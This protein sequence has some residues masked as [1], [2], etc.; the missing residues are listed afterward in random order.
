MICNMNYIKFF[1]IAVVLC[2]FYF[3]SSCKDDSANTDS[4]TANSSNDKLADAVSNA[5]SDQ[6]YF[7]GSESCKECHH[8]FHELWATSRHGNSF[9][10]VTDEFVK[11][12]LPA[13][14]GT[15]E[16]ADAQYHADVDNKVITEQTPEGTKSYPM[17]YAVGGKNVFYLITELDGGKMQT[18][19]L[20]YDVMLKKWY[21]MAKSGVRHSHEFDDAPYHWKDYP[22][23]FNSRC[24]GCHVSQYSQNY[25][26]ETD[27][28]QTTWKE[29]GINCEACHGPASEHIRV[30]KEAMKE[31]KMPEDLKMI[32]AVQSHGSTPEAV[33]SAC[34]CCHTKGGAI[35]PSYIPGEDYYDH[36]DLATY[37]NVDYYPDGRDL[38][39]NYTFTSWSLSPCAKNSKLDCM[40]CHTSSGRYRFHDADK[41]NDACVECHKSKVDNIVKHSHHKEGA[42]KC[43]QC[44]MPTTRFGNM[45]RSDH[46][47]RPPMPSATIKFKS[48]NACNICHKRK[49]PEWADKKVRQWHEK[50][51]QKETI[52]VAELV[53]QARRGQWNNLPKMLEYVQAPDSSEIFANSL[54]RLMETCNDESK[55]PVL[56]KVMK[57]SESPLVRSSAAYAF[58]SNL[59][60]ESVA[61]LYEAASDKSRIVRVKAGV[62]L[63]QV[64]D[65]YVPAKYKALVKKAI[66]EYLT[67]LE[68]RQ[69][70]GTS[71]YNKGNY[72]M[73]LGK[74]DK[75]IESFE[76]ASRLQYDFV[77]P[78]VNVA[79]AYNAIGE[80]EK[81]L[82][83]LEEAAKLA[84]KNSASYYNMALLLAEMNQTDKSEN[85]FR[86]VLE[87]EPKNAGA[88][89][90]LGVMLAEKLPQESLTFCKKAY[91]QAPG[92]AKYGYTYAFYLNQGGQSDKAIEILEKMIENKVYNQSSISLLVNIY[93]TTGQSEKVE[94]LMNKLQ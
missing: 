30:C 73:G 47:M 59:T 87:L 20:A 19:P 11:A 23:T 94:Q 25:D 76:I 86:K 58:N 79:M 3:I 91:E 49:G 31:G 92:E 69:D 80:N 7:T 27:T 42:T 16:I 33:D 14:E 24:Y 35:T 28:Y 36:F 75:A 10:I 9:N 18:M 83:S 13:H 43:I 26:F 37:E 54:I 8:K 81:A 84:P 6:G 34:S 74:Y 55:W 64:P 1:F 67:S 66:D 22:Y 89:Y 93:N 90:N 88:A 5:H 41:A 15:I 78:R 62:S 56:L 44:H 60:E 29:P 40:Y 39:E 53:Q 71:H 46:S 65:E 12:N 63:S 4:A 68:A 48:P 85:A 61:A 21:D 45:M 50:D 57:E 72:Y 52:E 17:K 77:P 2:G 82:A 51:Y 32:M 38:G 70:D